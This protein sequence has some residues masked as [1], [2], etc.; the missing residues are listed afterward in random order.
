MYLFLTPVRNQGEVDDF[1]Y[2]M[3]NTRQLEIVDTS[4][5]NRE[6]FRSSVFSLRKRGGRRQPLGGSGL[7]G[8][9]FPTSTDPSLDVFA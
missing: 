4:P 8:V 9:F 5:R 2:A 1:Q 3:A 6:Y 7:L